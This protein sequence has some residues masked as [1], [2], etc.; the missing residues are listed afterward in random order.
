VTIG[1]EVLPEEVTAYFRNARGDELGHFSEKDYNTLTEILSTASKRGN[2]FT[3]GA[4][5]RNNELIAAA[6]FLKDDKRIIFLKGGS[7]GLGRE[8]GAMHLILDYVLRKEQNKNLLF[9]FGGSVVNSV[10]AVLS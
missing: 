1:A 7:S 5:A 6:G 2:A 8:Q 4:F 10:A 3:L 9:D